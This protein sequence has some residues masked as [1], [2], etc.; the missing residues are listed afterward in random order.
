ML[1]STTIIPKKS[2]NSNAEDPLEDLYL[3]VRQQIFDALHGSILYQ[4]LQIAGYDSYSIRYK[5]SL[6][7]NSIK[8]TPK[9]LPAFHRLCQ[10]V[11]EKLQFEEEIDFRIVSNAEVNA[12][13]HLG[14]KD[15]PHTITINSAL[16]NLMNDDEL[17]FVVGHEIGHLIHRDGILSLLI[18]FTYPND[19]EHEVPMMLLHKIRL[20][21]QL[22]EFMADRC[23]YIGCGNLEA[24]ITAL[25]KL[26]S[27]LDLAKMGV[28]IK[29]LI[30]ENLQSLN[31]FLEGEGVSHDT[32][33]VSPI[34]IQALNLYATASERRR[35]S[36]MREL[37]SV[38]VKLGDS[39]MERNLAAFIAT[40][41]LVLALAD[42]TITDCERELM[43]NQL[44]EAT[45]FPAEYLGKICNC[46]N[47]E[48]LHKE[49]IKWLLENAPNCRPWML[50]YVIRMV[51]S[52]KTLSDGQG[53]FIYEFGQ[54]LGMSV[55]EI[56]R[57][58]ALFIRDAYQARID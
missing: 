54:R 48:E 42:G 36:G 52:D 11:K 38:L 39:E 55:E 23:G 17:R 12:W 10:E 32:H 34:R 30:E 4:S 50:K 28:S 14:Q 9:L 25:Y 41:G 31:Y 29:E 46:D 8:V 51:F 7:G 6:Q 40:T 2:A 20:N 18:N 44:S 5:S 47:L 57:T 3:R 37:L 15:T 24:C 13:A 33:P 45:V 56:A 22:A 21:N 49:S 19:D 43:L 53:D 26:Q 58:I 16:F 1:P 35:V 27:G